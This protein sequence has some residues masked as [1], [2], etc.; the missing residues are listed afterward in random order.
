MPFQLMK[1]NRK[2]FIR[3][4]VLPALFIAL[5]A[6]GNA[7]LA[8]SQDAAQFVDR[9][10]KQ[11]IEALRAPEL[12]LGQ[13]TDRFRG[14]LARG[15]DIPFIGRFVIGRHWRAATPGQRGEYLALY[16]EFF[17]QTYVSRIGDYAGQ[18]FAVTGARAV[19]A[20]DFVVRTEIGRA[21]GRPFTTDWRVRL[22][23]GR[24]RVIDIMVEG[25]SMAVTQRSEFA[26]VARRGGLEGLL[27]TL[28]D[29]T[30]K[31]SEIAALN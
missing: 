9:L 11:T 24:Y 28:R 15:F 7:A 18:S 1:M 6:A 20:K 16:S 29:R 5:I 21:A 30:L 14:L 23:D 19:N 17:L 2:M 8:S 12:S 27:M 4:V 10:G 25:I 31:I 3:R 13:R 22:I 26:S